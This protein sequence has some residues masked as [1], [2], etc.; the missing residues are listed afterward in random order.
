MVSFIF[1]LVFSMLSFGLNI[2]AIYAQ[3]SLCGDPPPVANETLKGEISGQAQLLTKFL[4]DTQLSGKIESSRAEIFSKYPD[5]EE[6]R[7]NAFFEY[8][9]CVLIMNDNNMSNKQKIEELKKVKREFGKPVSSLD[10]KTIQELSKAHASLR[11]EV[12]KEQF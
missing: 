1:L 11:I 9:V 6:S 8:Q 10:Q 3:H 2:S 5:A 7:T 4:G 12:P